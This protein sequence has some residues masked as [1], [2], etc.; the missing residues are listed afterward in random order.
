MI[1]FSYIFVSNRWLAVRLPPLQDLT[2]DSSETPRLHSRRYRRST[3]HSSQSAFQPGASLSSRSSKS[4]DSKK[5]A[6]TSRA[7][8]F[9]TYWISENTSTVQ[10]YLFLSETLDS[11]VKAEIWSTLSIWIYILYICDKIYQWHHRINV[12][13]H[14][15]HGASLVLPSLFLFQCL[16]SMFL[17]WKDLSGKHEAISWVQRQLSME[18]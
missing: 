14:P 13:T 11:I 5:Q 1:T 10:D 4:K 18:W 6:R 16:L 8:S 12:P 2:S 17:F 3:V 15:D 9:F 7:D